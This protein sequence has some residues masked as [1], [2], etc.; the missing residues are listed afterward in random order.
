MAKIRRVSRKP[1]YVILVFS[2][3]I[4]LGYAGFIYLYPPQSSQIMEI[5]PLS[6]VEGE[7]IITGILQKDSPAGESGNYVVILSDMRA[8]VLDV[9]GIDALLGQTVS[10]TGILAL[11]PPAM[12]VDSI[13]PTE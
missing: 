3:I 8:V 12:S 5:T 7:A 1:I 2:L 10:V 4:A 9:Q 6:L 13:T 11:D